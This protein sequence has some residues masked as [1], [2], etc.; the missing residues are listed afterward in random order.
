MT[1][2]A[3]GPDSATSPAARAT[4]P[5]K[6]R[7]R[8]EL[9]QGYRSYQYL[10]AGTDYPDRAYVPALGRVPGAAM[11]WDDHVEARARAFEEQHWVVS[12]HDHLSLRPANSTE[13]AEYRR[14]GREATPYEGIAH[15]GVDLFFDGGPAAVSMIRSHTPWDWDDAISDL[16]MRQSDW[17]HQGLVTPVRNLEEAQ[18]ARAAGQVGV[19]LTLEAATPIGNDVDRLDILYGLG[20]R[21]LG[22]VYSESN[23]LGSGLADTGDAGLTLLGRRA[24][25]RMN[26]LGIIVDVSHTGDETAL[27]AARR[28][29]APV[30]ITHAGSRALWP[31]SR[32]K[33]DEVI[34]A[35]ADTGGFIGV[36][37]APHTTVTEAHPRHC[38][39]SVMEHLERCLDLVGIDHVALGPDTNFG[40]HVAWHRVFASLFGKDDGPATDLP[41]HEPVEY[42]HGCE[43]PGESVR[44][45]IRWLF[46][47]GYSDD[48]I[49]KI[50]G[51]NVRRVAAEVWHS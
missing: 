17:A 11:R 41:S 30:V 16:S 35:C 28:S 13:F 34:R 10:T 31:T 51:G 8:L 19:V 40:D 18:R 9:W 25:R 29:T 15:S 37:A 49:A 47:H 22:L 38:L 14:S 42:V 44:N 36:E 4:L 46:V 5:E 23:Q 21:L 3:P 32:M 33:P 20:V 12:A 26:D 24:L 1:L 45:M 27:D 7:R 50:A 2:P 48:D 43:N 39:D 6:T